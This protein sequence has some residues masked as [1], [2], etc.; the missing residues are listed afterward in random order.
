[1][2]DRTIVGYQSAM[3]ASRRSPAA[4][5]LRVQLLV[6]RDCTPIVPVGVADLLRK[7]SELAATMPGAQKRRP[8]EV[9]LISASDRRVVRAAG[10][11]ELRCQA[12]VADAGPADLVL[13]PALDPDI[14]E[15]LEK[16]R[17]AVPFL[18]RAY[19]RGADLASACTGAFL[20]AEAGVLDGRPATTHW[21]FQGLFASTYP[22][23]RLAPQ[24]VMVDSGRVLT[25]GGAT[26]FLNLTLVL[27][28]RLLGPEVARAASKMFLID[29]NKAPQGAYAMF[30][31]QKMHDD[32]AIQRA[33]LLIE[34]QL[35]DGLSVEE[36]ARAAHLSTRTFM[37]RFRRATGNGP[38]EYIQRVRVEAA[39]RALEGGDHSVV[40]VAESVG[41]GDPVAFRKLFVRLTGLTPMDYRSR[42]GARVAPAWL[43]ARRNP[44]PGASNGGHRPP[45][46]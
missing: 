11:I 7:A 39:K 40:S 25:A 44:R 14:G 43:V 35:A 1:M 28:E 5:P 42:Y 12:T 23:V 31:T 18:R 24:A 30:S 13:A 32:Q 4:R 16:N 37:R 20:L 26:S 6:L 41:Y 9:S 17:R 19:Q 8:L 36:L 15:Q 27:V 29:V 2:A 22:R 33:Q 46:H 38:R 10:G 34:E 45:S 21:A 3:P